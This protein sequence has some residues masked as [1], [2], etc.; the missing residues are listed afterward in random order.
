MA[1]MGKKDGRKRVRK[2]RHKR[3]KGKGEKNDN[4]TDK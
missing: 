2:L 1:R 3:N 4:S